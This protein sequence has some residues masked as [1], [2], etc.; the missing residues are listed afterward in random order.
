VKEMQCGNKRGKMKVADGKTTPRPIFRLFRSADW[1]AVTV[2]EFDKSEWV[3]PKVSLT[4][5]GICRTYY[6]SSPI[7]CQF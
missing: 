6:Y 4:A 2:Q 3:K 1:K 7:A 5:F